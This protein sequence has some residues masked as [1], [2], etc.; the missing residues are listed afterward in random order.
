ME[1]LIYK[2][3]KIDS[4]N[5]DIISLMLSYNF[6]AGRGLSK[7]PQLVLIFIEEEK[8]YYKYNTLRIGRGQT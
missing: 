7:H 1:C 5:S 8:R 4:I 3:R 6:N 2:F